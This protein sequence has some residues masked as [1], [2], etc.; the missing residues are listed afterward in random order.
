[1][2]AQIFALDTDAHY[3]RWKDL[4]GATNI[5]IIRVFRRIAHER[6]NP[7]GSVKIHADGQKQVLNFAHIVS[8]FVSSFTR[9]NTT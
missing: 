8:T 5:K 6:R 9:N 1:M 2:L 4:N 3:R 7:D